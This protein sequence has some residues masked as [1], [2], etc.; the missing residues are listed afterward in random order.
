MDDLHKLK[1]RQDRLRRL[2]E[3][4][5][6]KS[7]PN[8][9]EGNRH[10]TGEVNT[11][12]H[13]YADVTQELS[14][15][16]LSFD[17]S[18]TSEEMNTLLDEITKEIDGD[19]KG[20][21]LEPVFLSLIDG[22]MRAFKIG[23]KQGITAT[24]LYSEC[25]SFSYDTPSKSSFTL[26]S[27]TEN[28]TERQNIAEYDAT[29]SY[30][31][32]ELTRG[33]SQINMR[34]GKKMNDAKDGHFDGNST[35]Q[36]SYGG[37]PIYSYKKHAKSEG[38]SNQSAETDHA[39]PCNEVCNKL[40]ANKGLT[41][42]DIKEIVNVEENLVVTSRENNRGAK[43]GKFAKSQPQLEQEIKQGYAEDKNGKRTEL[44]PEQIEVR[45]N[46]VNKQNTAQKAMDSETNKKVADNLVNNKN[47]QKKLS[48][49]AVEAA[50]H[51]SIGDAILFIIKPIYFE[52]QDCLIKGIEDG[53]NASSFKEALTIRVN[54][55]KSFAVSQIGN[56]L[57]GGVF[58]FM[59]SFVSMLL[60]GIVN[61]FVGVFKAIARTI[62]EGIKILMQAIPILRD[63][64][65]SSAQKGDAIL[66]VA[67]GSLSIFASIGIEAWLDSLGLVEPWSILISSV[68]TA[69]LTALVMHLLDKMDLFG[70]KKEARLN[71]IDEILALK[72]EDTKD[73][74]LQMVTVLA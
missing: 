69:V 14:K 24:R 25:K 61:C 2:Q 66:K 53:V 6:L 31:N 17:A 43:V 12:F 39:V 27:Y 11:D 34:D 40:K 74:M 19:P 5:H 51:Q 62:K 16:I 30:G 67:A 47:V 71:R 54:R 72:V 29:S 46:M 41:D 50:G 60:E 28:I 70:L 23:T 37:E 22:T 64:N 57:K 45:K 35:A 58:S 56:E 18:A 4:S 49:D 59:K 36:D 33:D 52:L 9:I 44:T 48:K 20:H 68:L 63:K 8:S 65:A 3:R 10:L 1:A 32:G 38:Q 42:N 7:V 73:E 26:D 55:I 13:A 15:R 21:I